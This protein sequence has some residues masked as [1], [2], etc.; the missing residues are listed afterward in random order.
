MIG[1]IH[2]FIL[3]AFALTLAPGGCKRNRTAAKRSQPVCTKAGIGWV[4]KSRPRTYRRAAI[5]TRPS[6]REEK[7]VPVLPDRVGQWARS[8]KQ[9]GRL[10]CGETA[11]FW[12]DLKPSGRIKGADAQND[13]PA[14][15]CLAHHAQRA[16]LKPG[17]VPTVTKVCVYVDLDKK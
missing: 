3:S 13:C 6:R 12:F 9:A 16:S 11:V 2:I 10:R 7:L 4:I 8:C 15:R 1:R 14:A 5:S 17:L